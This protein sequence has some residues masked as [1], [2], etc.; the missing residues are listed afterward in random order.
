MP[1]HY[2]TRLLW[3]HEA[4]SMG[5]A[6][7]RTG[8]TRRSGRCKKNTKAA[9]Y[10]IPEQLQTAHF[11]LNTTSDDI[12]WLY[13]LDGRRHHREVLDAFTAD[14]ESQGPGLSNISLP[15]S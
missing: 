12:R 7:G 15:L 9:R 5:I 3:E 6:F 4:E 13:E 1:C 10:L 14:E 11:L 8:T 2:G